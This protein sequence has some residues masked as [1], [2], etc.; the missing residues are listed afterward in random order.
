MDGVGDFSGPCPRAWFRHGW[1]AVILIVGIGNPGRRYA[2]TR[3]NLGWMVVDAVAARHGFG[4]ERR[5]FAGRVREGRIGEVPAVL[6]K[7]TT[8]VNES[9]RSVGEAVRWL[10]LA[11]EE[12][13]VCLDDVHLPLGRLRIRRKGSSG[14]HRGLASIIEALG[15]EEVP[16]LRVGIGPRADEEPAEGTSP[17]VPDRVRYV[18]GRFTRAERPVVES[19]VERAAE[20]VACWAN[21]GIEVCM[22][23]FN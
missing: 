16:R 9:G 10:D 12:V 14:G 15:T 7:P 5:R 6:L 4:R 21:E 20:A 23:R 3:H 11:P 2:G 13:L 18:L 8:Y 22:N 1:T 17:A 19:A